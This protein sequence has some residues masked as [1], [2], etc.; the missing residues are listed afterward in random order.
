MIVSGRNII[1][2]G[3]NGID[4]RSVY[5]KEVYGVIAGDGR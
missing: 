3:I 2:A 4:K 5:F 1:A